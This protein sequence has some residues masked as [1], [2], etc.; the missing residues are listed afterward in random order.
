MKI[1]IQTCMKNGN[2]EIENFRSKK[3][4]N[5]HSKLYEKWKKFDR[6][7]IEIF[8]SQFFSDAI[9]KILQFLIL[10]IDLFDIFFE[11]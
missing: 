4:E 1:F 8:R 11:N 5:F 6:K 3:I 9:S 10:L 7:K 2:F